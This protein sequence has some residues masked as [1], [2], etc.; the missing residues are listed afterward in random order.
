M[1][2]REWLTETW[3][4]SRPMWPGSRKEEPRRQMRYVQPSLGPLFD[5][6]P[7]DQTCAPVCKS[8]F[9]LKFLI[10]KLNQRNNQY[11]APSDEVDMEDYFQT[12][13]RAAATSNDQ[14][15]GAISSKIDG[16]FVMTLD[17]DGTDEMLAV[18]H[19]LKSYYGLNYAVVVSSPNHYWVIVDK[20]DLAPNLV[21]M[22]EIIPG[23]DPRYI[24]VIKKR[25]EIVLRG[26]PRETMPIFPD[27]VEFKDERV[28][29]WYTAF[30]DAWQSEEMRH[31]LRL[32]QLVKAIKEKN[33]AALAAS[34]SFTV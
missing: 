6:S 25:W 30:K 5:M 13:H 1:G 29:Q 9:K 24:D 12:L 31:I 34:P 20:I 28:T 26:M 10:E 7:I 2:F 19:V 27:S 33:V 22:M 21:K 23:I 4:K 11:L 14:F 17:C 8:P 16:Q 3:G 32:K 18:S 15:Y